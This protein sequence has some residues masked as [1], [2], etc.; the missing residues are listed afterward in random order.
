MMKKITALAM[1][2]IMSILLLAGCSSSSNETSSTS[3]SDDT[4]IY[5]Q[6]S[7]VGDSSITIEVGTMKE[8]STKEGVEPSEGTDTSEST[9]TSESTTS[10]ED[11]SSTETTNESETTAVD[12]SS[13]ETNREQPENIG[14]DK[15]DS[16]LDLTG[17]E[18][19]IK[20]T[21]DTVIQRG[22]MGGGNPMNGEAPS[23]E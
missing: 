7:A 20:I 9:G 11:S 1:S 6:V 10:V 2:F 12:S 5:G 15:M 16:M 3:D 14:N 23:G 18:Q 8:R 21:D 4:A 19:E 22:G 17:E 13:S